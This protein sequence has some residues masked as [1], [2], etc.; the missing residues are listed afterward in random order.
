MGG[1]LAETFL[2]LGKYGFDVV[3]FAPERAKDEEEGEESIL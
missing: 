2:A 1:E 3:Q